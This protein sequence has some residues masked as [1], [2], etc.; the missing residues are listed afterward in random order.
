MRER[1]VAVDFALD[2]TVVAVQ[3]ESGTGFP[4]L[5]GSRLVP[6][7]KVPV[8]PSLVHFAGDGSVLVGEEVIARGLAGHPSTVQR[9]QHYI[10][11]QSPARF[12]AGEGTSAG[13]PE[14]GAAFLSVLLEA[15][16][17]DRIRQ[18]DLVLVVPP[19]AGQ[20]YLDWIRTIRL[21]FG[22]S[23]PAC[24]ADAVTATV[25]GYGRPDKSG[26]LYLIIDAGEGSITATAALTTDHDGVSGGRLLRVLGTAVDETGSARV[27]AWIVEDVLTRRRL[28]PGDP[29]VK[30]VQD[31]L[32]REAARVRG[33]LVAMP[34][35]MFDVTDPV[36]GFAV[37]AP[38][39]RAD[40]GRVLGA[41][42]MY[43]AVKRVTG[44]ALAAAQGRGADP[45]NL[46]AVLLTGV[47][48]TL[49][50]LVEAVQ[51]QFGAGRVH[52]DHTLDA[53][54]LGALAAVPSAPADRIRND[55]AVR[56]WDAA[57]REHRYRFLVRAGARYPSAGQ[58]GRFV[59]SA[60]YD[61]QTHLGIPLY[62]FGRQGSGPGPAIELV[63]DEAGGM[64]VAGPAPDAVTGEKPLWVNERTPTLLVA[65]P[66]A[67]KGE[68][69]FE[70]V[71]TIDAGRQLC[72][73]ARDV[74]T[75]ELV[76]RDM[77][78]YRLE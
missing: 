61:G 69:R 40:L 59:I 52:A 45:R 70:L 51:E 4:A 30:Q 73:T 46:T 31:Q 15:A 20:P 8:V 75:G 74:L 27:D 28:R 66:P 57:S 32:A 12:V 35:V 68:P 22:S 72:L 56:Y 5:P 48:W 42:G 62:R 47:C 37:A 41:R 76:K 78:V 1:V 67:V 36:S 60:A 64:R 7:H 39:S 43:G 33:K 19:G 11:T 49:P 38:V 58:A 63:S 50:G 71:F 23:R 34:G 21:P 17:G 77:P 26:L 65:S 29:R 16:C 9:V 6:G 2:S 3:D 25:L 10:A 24:L 13:Y 14:A 44:R 55:Y 53:R 54:V 18:A